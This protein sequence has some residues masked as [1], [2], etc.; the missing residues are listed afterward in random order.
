MG[1]EHWWRLV[2]GV[3]VSPATVLLP[4]IVSNGLTATTS[5]SKQTF[6]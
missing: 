3:L 6:D 5:R 4:I 2:K 1:H